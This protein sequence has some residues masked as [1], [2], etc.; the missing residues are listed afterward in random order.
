MTSGIG[1][2]RIGLA[3]S[4]YRTK[5]A[6]CLLPAAIPLRPAA[7]GAGTSG[8]YHQTVGAVSESRA[9]RRSN[10]IVS[11]SQPLVLRPSSGWKALDLKDAW[12]HRELLYF[13]AWRDVKV[14][15]KQTAL[16]VLWVLIR[17]VLTVIM[18]SLVFGKLV[19]VPSDGIPYPLFV[20]AAMIPW[21]FFSGAVA[22]ASL[23]LVGN[24][25]LITKVY[26]PRLLIPFGSVL[27]SLL[28]V[29]IA[30]ILILA[31]MGWYGSVPPLSA[32]VTIPL[33]VVLTAVV[34][35]AISLCLGAL[36][37]T[38]RDVGNAVPF[39]LQIWMWATPVVYPLSL[40]P[41]R[42]RWVVSLNPM[43]GIVEA[44]RSALFGRPLAWFSFSLS[45]VFAVTVLVAG[46]F[47]FRRAERT[48]ADTV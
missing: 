38:Y 14:R 6:L 18:L 31:L 8:V 27:S 11:S 36:N 39:L 22:T 29:A 19:R 41:P 32:L 47:Y 45:C 34:A 30:S 28:D 7:G 44:F 13:F 48:F 20:L 21:N 35:L 12:R 17:P 40:V 33:L 1:L 42:W 3:P 43:S 5:P 4:G 16:G 46:L 15:Y 10:P 2:V 24:A 23:S 9:A 26:F 37:V 25:H